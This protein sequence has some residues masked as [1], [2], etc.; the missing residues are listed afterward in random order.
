MPFFA[1]TAFRKVLVGASVVGLLA[2]GL[3]AG[4][5]TLTAQAGTPRAVFPPAGTDTFSSTATVGVQ[6]GCTGR[7]VPVHLSGN[8]TVMR[9]APGKNSSGHDFIP[10]EMIT[11]D[12]KGSSPLGP[13]KVTLNPAMSSTGQVTAMG[14]SSDFP[15][16]SFFDIFVEVSAGNSSHLHNES[17]I[18]MQA[19]IKAI[20]PVG[21]KY[22]NPF[23]STPLLDPTGATV[24]CLVHELHIPTTT[25]T[26]TST[27]TTSTTVPRTT[28]SCPPTAPGCTTTTVPTCVTEVAATT[29]IPAN[30]QTPLPVLALHCAAVIPAGTPITIGAQAAT[31]VAPASPGDTTIFVVAPVTFTAAAGDTVTL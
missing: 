16:N 30:T 20:P 12:L 3:L 19:T 14:K 25:T 11:L 27:T 26:T 31:L 21:S 24:A 29:L 10:T 4:I 23:G 13:V 2:G 5:E 9:K 15:A 8:T 6:P 18:H 1:R 17:P 22:K 7:T 28:T